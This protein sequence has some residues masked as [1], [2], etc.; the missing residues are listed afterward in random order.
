MYDQETI[1]A[2]ATAPGMG[3]IAIVRVSGAKALS[4]LAAIAPGV[5]LELQ[6]RHAY[7]AAFV[8]ALGQIDDG[9]ATFFKG[10]RS[11]TGE[12]VVEFGI[13]GSIYVQQRLME[14]LITAGARSA[15]PG[16]FTLRAFLNRKMDL[17]QA[18]AVA[19][20]IQSE[21]EAQHRLAMDQ[22]RGGFGKRIEELRQQL[23]DFSALIELELDFSEEDVQFA[24]RVELIALIDRL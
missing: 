5:P 6:E 19:D 9:I 22:L 14:A 21:S 11:F 13:H 7:R 3:A 8:D 15:L 20:L 1:V 2:I 18:E 4:L 17:S 12:D 24:Q 10:P 23:I 16:E